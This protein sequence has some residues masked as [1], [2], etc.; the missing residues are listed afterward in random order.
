MFSSLTKAYKVR[1]LVQAGRRAL[2][3]RDFEKARQFFEQA[4]NIN[5]R[6]LRTA[7]QFHQG[8]LSYLGR[9]E[10]AAGLL[11]QAKQSL[12]RAIAIYHEDLLAS[13][14]LGMTMLRLGSETD[15]LRQIKQTLQRLQAWIDG[16]A[17]SRASE[18][19]WDINGE[20][21]AEI[22][23]ALTLS[24]ENGDYVSLLKSVE[25]IGDEVDAECDRARRDESRDFG[26]W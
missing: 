16:S 1:R 19:F 23:N 7:A 10:Y 26:R 20:I 21:R 11:T 5:P 13:L 2:L 24:E 6:Y 17:G 25:W 18:N 22:N 15:G 3:R 9:A 12:E 14:Y 8:V 4:A